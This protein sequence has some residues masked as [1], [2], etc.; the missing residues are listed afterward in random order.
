M[1]DFKAWITKIKKDS[2]WRMQRVAIQPLQAMEDTLDRANQT[3]KVVK[4][5]LQKEEV[6]VTASLPKHL[7]LLE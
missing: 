4:E 2:S 5:V 7:I 6:Q 1:M 3:P